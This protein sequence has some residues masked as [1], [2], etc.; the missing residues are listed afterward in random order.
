MPRLSALLAEKAKADIEVGGSS[1]GIVF[2]VLW[3]ERFSDEEWTQLVGL[4][5][6]D[7]L[8]TVLPRVLASW[9]LV[10]DD[11]HAVPVTADAIEQHN[12]PNTL[13]FAVE[14]RALNSDLSGKVTSSNSRVT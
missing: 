5:G 6:R 14:R 7:Y 3:R 8:K 13:L 10:D 9:D 4:T 11:G 2:Y 1:L 12:I